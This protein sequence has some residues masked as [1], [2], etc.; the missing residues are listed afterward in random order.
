MQA[1]SSGNYIAEEAFKNSFVQQSLS[2]L[3]IQKPHNFNIV[4][5]GRKI[6]YTVYRI[7]S[8]ETR[9]QRI[10]G[11]PWYEKVEWEWKKVNYFA[12]IQK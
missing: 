10:H 6:Q 7:N 9:I 8:T 11:V 3:E 1:S 2:K 4:V 12:F 5:N